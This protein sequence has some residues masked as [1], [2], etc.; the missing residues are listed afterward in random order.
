MSNPVK[1]IKIKG[2][3][4]TYINYKLKTVSSPIFNQYYEMFYKFNS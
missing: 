3:D 2:K 4:K 1:S